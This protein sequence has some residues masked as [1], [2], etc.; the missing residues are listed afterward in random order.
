MTIINL[1]LNEFITQLSSKLPVPGGGGASAL[2]GAIGVSLCS[3]VANLTSGKSKYSEYQ[4]DI[5]LIIARTQV[6]IDNLLNLINKDAEVFEPLSKAYGMP[7]N[8]PLREEI[9]E[10]ALINAC[11]VPMEILYEVESIL[12][13]IEQLSVKGSKLAVSDVGVSAAACRCAMESAVMNVLINTKL[14]KNREYALE[15]NRNAQSILANGICRT[16]KIYGQIIN[17]LR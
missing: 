5:D 14:M 9:L 2:I 4:N 3:M 11:A 10:E 12:D 7:K 15:T 16:N 8:E 17:E 13:I 1:A 6:S